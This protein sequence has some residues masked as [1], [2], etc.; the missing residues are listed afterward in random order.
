MAAALVLGVLLGP[1]VLRQSQSLPLMSA[2]GRVIAIKEIETAL[3]RQPSGAEHATDGLA[4]GMSFRTRN[5]LL[6]RTFAMTLG[7]A[8]LACREWGEWVIEVLAR[9]PRA[10]KGA[11]GEPYL[12]GGTHFPDVIRMAVEQRMD[13]APLTAAE[14]AEATERAWRASRP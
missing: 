5:G 14:E 13:G 6:C 11:T 10:R 12:Q 4:I 1:I 8:G 3:M 7:P 9:N 2:N